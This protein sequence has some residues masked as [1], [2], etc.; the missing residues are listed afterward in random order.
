[1][2]RNVFDFDYPPVAFLG[3]WLW[4]KSWYKALT[5]SCGFRFNPPRSRSR[6]IAAKVWFCCRRCE[7]KIYR[8]ATTGLTD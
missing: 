6:Y 8:Q 5:G 2:L 1:M 4:L 7:A 3:A